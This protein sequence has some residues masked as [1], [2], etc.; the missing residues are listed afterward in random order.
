VSSLFSLTTRMKISKEKEKHREGS[1]K[2]KKETWEKI[3]I[4]D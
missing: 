1:L 3:S 2:N 4:T